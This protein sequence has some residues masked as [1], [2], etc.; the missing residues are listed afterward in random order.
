M[1]SPSLIS[2][3]LPQMLLP[4]LVAVALLGL[5]ALA[6][7]SRFARLASGGATWI[8]TEKWVR[9][10]DRRFDVDQHLLNHS[11]LFGAAIFILAATLTYLIRPIG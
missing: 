3:S 11:R 9:A 1:G 7:P 10:M 6:A 2:L 8:D 5:F 4:A